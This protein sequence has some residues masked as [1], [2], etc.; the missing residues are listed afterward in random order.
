MSTTAHRLTVAPAPWKRLFLSHIS[1]LSSPEFV[2]T[3]LHQA[4]PSSPTPF[5]PRLR[6][7][8]FRGMWGEL[9][10]NSHNDAP[11]NERIYES[12][13]LTLTT[14]VRMQKVT[15]IFTSSPGHASDPQQMQGSGGG[16]P[17]EAAFWIKEKGTQ[18]RISGTAYVV[19]D[20][21]E[22]EEG[23]KSSGVRTVKSEV[24]GRMRPVKEGEWSWAT[25]LTAHFGNLS[26][27]MRGTWRNPTPGTPVPAAGQEHSKETG[28]LG[29]KVTDL[30]DPISRSNFRVMV[31]KPDKVEQLE[32][33][34]PATARRWRYIFE[35][36]DGKASW[37]TEE[38]WP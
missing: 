26:P 33:S 21:I 19:A 6:Y 1:T 23:E 22:G 13:M 2:L 10:E 18:W 15:D 36:D 20:D 12:D 25:E 24:G 38:L 11:R 27:S 3:T 16:G 31:I 8:I 35:I 30:H 9:P 28:E 29:Q 17:V 32:I 14:D 5:V 7:C 34:D 4:S 37:R